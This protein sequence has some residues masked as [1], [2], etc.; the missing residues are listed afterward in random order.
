[1]SGRL[2]GENFRK[3]PVT[4]CLSL[5]PVSPLCPAGQE[6]MSEPSVMCDPVD[7]AA[8]FQ[9]SQLQ[10]GDIV[11]IQKALVND[12]AGRLAYPKVPAYLEYVKNRQVAACVL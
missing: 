6:I 1:M 7:M 11:C 9:Y 8:S 3:S 2:G 4:G 12:V 5:M 10:D